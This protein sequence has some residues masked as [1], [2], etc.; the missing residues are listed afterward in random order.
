MIVL[1]GFAKAKVVLA[2]SVDLNFSVFVCLLAVFAT[3]SM[4]PLTIA[5]AKTQLPSMPIG[6]C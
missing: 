6:R 3:T 4:Q 1:L 2:L 5:E